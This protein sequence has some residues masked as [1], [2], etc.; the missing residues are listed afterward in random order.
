MIKTISKVNHHY[1]NFQE[2]FSIKLKE[3][4]KFISYGDE[5]FFAKFELQNPDL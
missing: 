1:E 5:V 4:F 3:P 2:P